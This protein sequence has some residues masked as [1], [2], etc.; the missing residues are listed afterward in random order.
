MPDT[1][2]YRSTGDG[3][4][5]KVKLIDNLDTTFSEGGGGAGSTPAG[6]GTALVSATLTRPADTNAYWSPTRPRPAASCQCSSALR[7]WLAARA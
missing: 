6:G 7:A 1:Y 4:Q 3:S 2:Y 5:V